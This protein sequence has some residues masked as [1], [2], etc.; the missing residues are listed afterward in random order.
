M[1]GVAAGLGELGHSKLL[2]TPQFGPR[3]RVF[4]VLTDAELEPDPL[5]TGSVCDE[6]GL[7]VE[8]C[9]ADA[10]PTERSAEVPVGERLYSHAPLDCATCPQV[11]QGWEPSYAPFMHPEHSRDNPPS[12]YGFLDRRFRHRS[13][14][15]ARGCVRACMDHLEKAGL[16]EKSYR[17]PMIEGDQWVIEASEGEE[18]APGRP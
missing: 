2:L 17:T 7:C 10:I 8:A 4:V 13:I 12:Y 6:C 16:I 5:F 18:S 9:P 11:H 3:Q 15:G 14:C 1:A